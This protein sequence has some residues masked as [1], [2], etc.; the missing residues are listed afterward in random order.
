[1]GMH[2]CTADGAGLALLEKLCE[3]SRPAVLETL[4][5]IPVGGGGSILLSP[6]QLILPCQKRPVPVGAL[7]AGQG[8]LQELP[9]LLPSLLHA[10]GPRVGLL[11][12]FRRA[13]EGRDLPIILD[14]DL[15]VF[16]KGL[17]LLLERLGGIRHLL[18][19]GS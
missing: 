2:C 16:G 18:L 4:F 7:E 1:M 19:E 14:Q 11:I 3:K 9:A 13:L 10:L 15:L 6:C 12:A 5:G 8:L 17:L